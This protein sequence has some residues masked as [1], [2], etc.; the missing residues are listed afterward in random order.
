MR[1]PD[2]QFYEGLKELVPAEYFLPKQLKVLSI[3]CGHSDQVAKEYQALSAHFGEGAFDYI[4]IDLKPSDPLGKLKQMP[5][6]NLI[7]GDILTCKDSRL[8]D[9]SFDL[10]LFRHP[11]FTGFDPRAAESDDSV[12]RIIRHKI[13]FLLVE[14]GVF[15]VSVYQED[16]TSFFVTSD[17]ALE[18]PKAS[19]GGKTI[20]A[21]VLSAIYHGASMRSHHV[22][23]QYTQYGLEKGLGDIAA[24]KW[25]FKFCNKQSRSFSLKSQ[26]VLHDYNSFAEKPRAFFKKFILALGSTILNQDEMIFECYSDYIESINGFLLQAGFRIEKF[27]NVSESP[28]ESLERQLLPYREKKSTASFFAAFDEKQPNKALR[29][30]CTSN[31][32]DAVRI[33]DILVRFH[34]SLSLNPNEL[35]GAAQRNAFHYAAIAGGKLYESLLLIEQDHGCKDQGGKTPLDYRSLEP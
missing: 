34:S 5:R 7:A 24:D 10:V 8:V 19:G 30:A 13:P 14:D 31:S 29:R 2:S 33:V 21:I 27:H 18:D 17:T 25:M 6:L 3:G 4:G 32:Q 1:K 15:L 23:D 20:D 35:A 22:H 26:Y 11:D 16:E 9:N 12:K 28:G